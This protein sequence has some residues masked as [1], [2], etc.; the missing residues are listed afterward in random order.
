MCLTS[1]KC[2]HWRTSAAETRE[3]RRKWRH[4]WRCSRVTSAAR[5]W[6]VEVVEAEADRTPE[7]T[8]RSW[9]VGGTECVL[10]IGA[11]LTVRCW[12]ASK[13]SRS[14]GD[15]N[16]CSCQA[17]KRSASARSRSS[18]KLA[19]FFPNYTYKL[20]VQP[21]HIVHVQVHLQVHWK[22]LT[23]LRSNNSQNN[24]GKNNF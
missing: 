20:P 24:R 5:S 21:S 11:N 22:Y 15:L 10:L 9:T 8:E 14:A 6:L 1:S 19:S 18:E 2:F 13:V 16:S 4:L 7:N 17:K 12:N 23:F 3:C